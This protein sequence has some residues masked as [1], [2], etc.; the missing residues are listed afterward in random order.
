MRKIR[1]FF[2]PAKNLDSSLME[3][4]PVLISRNN[5]RDYSENASSEKIKRKKKRK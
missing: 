4:Y 3:R 1:Q 2:L 5:K